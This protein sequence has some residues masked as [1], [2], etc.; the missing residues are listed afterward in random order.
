MQTAEKRTHAFQ[1][2]VKQLL[3]LMIHSLYSNKEI[4]LRELISNSSDALDKLRFQ[5]L[6]SDALKGKDQNLKITVSYDEKAQTISITDNGIGMNEAEVIEHLGTI[7]KSGTKAFIEK[8]SGDQAKDSALIGQFGVGFYSSFMVADRVSV[9]TR[10]ADESAEQ[11]VLWESQGDGEYTLTA[12]EKPSQGTIVT[13]HLKDAEKDLLSDWRL[14]EI[15]TKYSDHIAFPVEMLK[16]KGDEDKTEGDDF[17]AVNTATALWS[18]S[19]S[20]ITEDEYKAFYKHIS[21]DFEDPMTWTHNRVEGK[22]EYTNLLFIPKRAPFDMFTAN[23]QHKGIKLYVKRVF[24]MDDSEV[25]MPNYLRFVSGVIDSADLPL[26]VSREIL[27]RNRVVDTI[28]AGSIKKVLGLL[29]NMAKNEPQDYI[30]FWKTFGQ[31]LKEGIV[32]DHDNKAQLSRL[33][34]FAS[35]HNDEAAQTTSLEDYIGRMKEGQEK[36]YYVTAETFHAAKSS[37]H[38]EIFRKKGIEVLLLSDRVDEWVTAHLGEFEG[39]KLESVA[40]G[41]LDLGE[42]KDEETDVQA[43]EPDFKPLLDAFKLALGDE[44]KDVR[45]SARLTDSPAC[46]VADANDMGLQMQRIFAAAGQTMPGSKPILELNPKH[47]VIERLKS[48]TENPKTQDWAHLL[49]GQAILAEGGQ[50]QDP[51]QFVKCMNGLLVS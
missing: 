33:L 11:G 37:P 23:A 35:T 36:I 21:H 30:A 1:T 40:K 45:L 31:V 42:L 10:R 15:I 25:F 4:F 6:H 49:L 29:E 22:T 5:A 51:S 41:G 19:K 8:L 16:A 26:N 3:Q 13:L 48:D 2:E 12:V 47:P 9:L 46:V 18:R 39:K 32:E 14:R 44:V 38:L 50:L 7:A 34:R 20:E 27:Q 28:R 24:I 17:E 43:M